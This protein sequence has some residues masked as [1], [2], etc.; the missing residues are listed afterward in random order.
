MQGVFMPDDKID[1]I[2]HPIRIRIITAIGP[3]EMTAGEIAAVVPG[4][5]PTTLYRH[6]NTL[7]SGGLLQIVREN[8]VRGTV[9]RVYR[10][11]SPNILSPED[12][13]GMSKEEYEKA[14]ITFVSAFITDFQQ[15]LESKQPEQ[16]KP[17]EDGVDISKA[18]IYLS[19]SE[20]YELRGTLQGIMKNTLENKSSPDRKKRMFSYLFVPLE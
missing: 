2:F 19:D 17:M 11:D 18:Q 5:P 4:V 6:I 8:Q 3:S 9:E 13:E 7:V 1:L 16:L 12:L 10:I 14:F 15:Y 20:Y